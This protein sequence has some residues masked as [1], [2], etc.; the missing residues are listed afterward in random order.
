MLKRILL[1]LFVTGVV[2][3]S[4]KAQ[5]YETAL[6]LRLS[7]NDA[8]VNNSVSVKHFVNRVVALEGLFSFK[9]VALGI[10][11]EVHQPVSSAPGLRWLF[12]GGGFIRFSEDFDAGAQGIL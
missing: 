12:G 9:P 11:A 1:L 4:A 6:G 5:N 2:M 10:L 8:T 3:I 7:S